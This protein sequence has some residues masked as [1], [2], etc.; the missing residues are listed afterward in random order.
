M[1]RDI[2]TVKAYLSKLEKNRIDNPGPTYRRAIAQGLAIPEEYLLLR[3][4]PSEARTATRSGQTHRSA[5]LGLMAAA[6]APDPPA[7]TPPDSFGARIG[8]E[9]LSR[10]EEQLVGE[11]VRV[12]LALVA[13]ARKR[14]ASEGAQ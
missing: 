10:S 5:A 7:Q 3:V 12:A 4:A 8:G 11:L 6:P 9:D 13:E 2:G 1:G 14:G